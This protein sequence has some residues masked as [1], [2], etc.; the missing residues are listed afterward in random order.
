MTTTYV[1]PFQKAELGIAPFQCVKVFNKRY[2]P[3]PGAP[4]QPGASCD[5]CGTAIVQCCVIRDVNGKEFIVGNE[6]VKK[7]GDNELTAQ[8]RKI[9]NTANREAREETKRIAR[10]TA[11][12]KAKVD[13]DEAMADPKF[14]Q[15]LSTLPHPIEAMTATKGA[16]RLS[17]IE[18]MLENGRAVTVRTMIESIKRMDD[19]EIGRLQF[20]CKRAL[21]QFDELQAK[22]DRMEAVKAESQYIG[23]VGDKLKDI[24]AEVVFVKVVGGYQYDSLLVKF[25]TPDNNAITTFA[26]ASSKGVEIGS[27][28]TLRWPEAGDKVILKGTVKKHDDYEGCKQTIL[29]RVSLELKGE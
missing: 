3:Y 17:Y 6:C 5:Y 9:R 23:E 20:V 18:W 21:D 22:R 16:T 25:V 15:L 7:T 1:H 11:E 2:Q 19:E 28:E 10:E 24:E 14:T 27:E 26:S 4:S 8:I 13:I 12:T 29:T